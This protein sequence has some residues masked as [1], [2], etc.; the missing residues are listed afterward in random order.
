[1]ANAVVSAAANSE[2]APRAPTVNSNTADMADEDTRPLIAISWSDMQITAKLVTNSAPPGG[3]NMFTERYQVYPKLDDRL[4]HRG[5]V[6]ARKNVTA[7]AAAMAQMQAMRRKVPAP[8]QFPPPAPP[9]KPCVAT[10]RPAA[11]PTNPHPAT[12][13]SSPPKMSNGNAAPGGQKLKRCPICNAGFN[14]GTYLKRHIASHSQNKPHKCDI[15]GWGFH[16]YCNLKR[17]YASHAAGPGAGF[18]CLHCP[19]SFSTKSVLSVHMR[20]AHGD[21]YPTKKFLASANKQQQ[22]QQKAGQSQ[23]QN[24]TNG[25][26]HAIAADNATSAGVKRSPVAAENERETVEEQKNIYNCSVCAQAFDKIFNLNKH[27][28]AAHP[29]HFQFQHQTEAK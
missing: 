26:T 7:T 6:K 16:Q 1:M 20:E 4:P 8:P 18:Q 19:A 12:P 22:M 2:F 24:A 28:K 5:I 13:V 11:I 27:M 25:A 21:K 14:K 10:A 9:G 23:Q 17:H 15:C 3:A 29:E